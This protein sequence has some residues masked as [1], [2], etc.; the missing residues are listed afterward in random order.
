MADQRALEA[1]RAEVEAVSGA[2]LELMGQRVG[3]A[4]DIA[5]TKRRRGMPLRDAHRE[6]ELIERLVSGYTGPLDAVGIRALFRTV[7]DTSVRLMGE[8]VGGELRVSAA[9]GPRVAVRAAGHL[10]GAGTLRYIAGPCAVESEAQI[11]TA[12]A[13]LHALGV[14]FLRGGAFKPRTSPYAFQGLGEE[15]LRML[16]EAGRRWG[17]AVVT[18]ATC[19][20][21]V[22]LVARHA[23]VIQ[24]GARNMQSYELLRAA[25]RTGKPVLLKRGLAAT[26]DEW[27]HAAEYVA[28]AGSEQIVLC[29][30]G[31]RTFEPETRFTLDLSSVPLAL[32]RTRLPVVVDVSHPA[33]RRDLLAPL[34]RAALAAGAHGV[35]VEVHPDPDAALSDAQQQ[36]SL[37]G[38]AALQRAVTAGL[39]SA[40]EHLETAH[41]IERPAL[42][43][44]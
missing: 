19:P 3:L 33:G 35:M 26:V 37:S 2:I 12:A 27:I 40:L 28:L 10:L 18:E 8:S 43:A 11:E 31:V 5:A 21:N 38:F 13:G 25:G 42:A 36:L 14:R 22:E 39:R 6:A 34:A 4:R 16:S 41:E 30:R 1:M 32:A 15:G 17:M 44:G 7:L 23:D 24:I 29:E 9:A 20:E